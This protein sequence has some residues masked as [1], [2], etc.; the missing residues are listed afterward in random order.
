M[1]QIGFTG[2]SIHKLDA[3]NRV[4]VPKRFQSLLS[5]DGNGDTCCV[6]TRGTEDCVSLFSIAGYEQYKRH[7]QSKPIGDRR[8]RAILR[9]FFSKTSL[10]QLDSAGRVLIPDAL[11]RFANLDKEVV[12]VGVDE[13][14]EIWDRASWEA[15][16]EEHE[17]TFRNLDE[18]L[19]D[20]TSPSGA[21]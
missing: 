13:R 2:E 17:I 14:A 20:G 4:F 18:V 6:L 1:S 16:E 12:M 9:K 15:F 19:G 5:A 21:V 3:K 10:T 11:K 8:K 7:L